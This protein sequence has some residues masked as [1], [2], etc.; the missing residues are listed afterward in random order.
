MALDAKKV[1]RVRAVSFGLEFTGC[2]APEPLAKFL[3]KLL[4]RQGRRGS[5]DAWIPSPVHDLVRRHVLQ[6]AGRASAAVFRWIFQGAAQLPSA[7]SSPCHGRLCFWKTPIRRARRCVGKI[8]IHR[9][10][11]VGAPHCG[12]APAI[13]P[14]LHAH[15]VYLPIVALERR[16]PSDVTIQTSR[17]GQYRGDVAKCR[18]SSCVAGLSVVPRPRGRVRPQSRRHEQTNRRESGERQ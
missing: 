15:V 7:Q 17:T 10:M 6:K 14:T 9:L 2:T 11:A 1:R 4:M 16:F 8:G 3:D 18:Q 13:G 5:P 12:R